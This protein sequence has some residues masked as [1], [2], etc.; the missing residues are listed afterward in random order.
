MCSSKV[1]IWRAIWQGSVFF[2]PGVLKLLLAT[3][4]VLFDMK[5][6][7]FCHVLPCSQVDVNRRFRVA[8]CLHNQ[9]D[10]DGGSTHL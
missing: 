9:G 5:F 2:I 6:R 3:I 8:Y 7:V 10:D 1:Q 4:T